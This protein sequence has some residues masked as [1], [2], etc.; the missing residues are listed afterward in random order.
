MRSNESRWNADHKRFKTS[1]V[2]LAVV[3][4]PSTDDLFYIGDDSG[5]NLE[6]LLDSG[7]Q[8][9]CNYL[10][11]FI[12]LEKME[13]PKYLSLIEMKLRLTGLAELLYK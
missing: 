12:D 9:M 13:V 8:H 10:T 6:W 11:Y 1:K 3:K 5:E 4:K 2:N 7:T